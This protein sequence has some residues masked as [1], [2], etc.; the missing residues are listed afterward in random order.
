MS[1]LPYPD[2]FIIGTGPML[3]PIICWTGTRYNF[4]KARSIFDVDFTLYFPY[5][6]LSRFEIPSIITY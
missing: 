6:E 2:I 1:M 5:R 4:A 3:N